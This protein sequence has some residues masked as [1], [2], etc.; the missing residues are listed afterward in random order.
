[1]YF[2]TANLNLRNGNEIKEFIP[3]HLDNVYL[4]EAETFVEEEPF[5][6]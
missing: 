3:A 4:F 6:K 2:V 1:M 5:K